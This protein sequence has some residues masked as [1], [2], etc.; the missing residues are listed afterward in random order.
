M[1]ST[2][3]W[4]AW[5]P[6]N[7][8]VTGKNRPGVSVSRIHSA[9]TMGLRISLLSTEHIQK[10]ESALPPLLLPKGERSSAPTRHTLSRTWL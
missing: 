8:Y 5:L 7:N 10:C 3:K 4:E 2:D 6:A 9:R 1:G